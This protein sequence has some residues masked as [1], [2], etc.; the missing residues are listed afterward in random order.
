[1]ENKI[2]RLLI[3]FF[4][5]MLV[6][7]FLSRAAAAAVVAK[8][9]VASV[10]SGNL[11]Y[12]IAGTG[13]VKADAAKY[14]ELAA[15]YK[16]GTVSVREG[17][18]VKRGDLLFAYDVKQLKEIEKEKE[19][20]LK[21]LRLQYQAIGVTDVST[22]NS[23]EKDAALLAVEN[24]KEDIDA[25]KRALSDVKKT[26]KENKEKA[27]KEAADALEETKASGKTA[28]KMSKRAVQ[29]LEEELSKMLLPEEEAGDVI[30]VYKKAA[31]E[32]IDSSISSALQ[33]VFQYYYGEGYAEHCQKAEQAKKD[34]QRARE[35][36]AGIEQKWQNVN[37]E[38]YRM[39]DP[40]TSVRN[41]YY[42]QTA[43]KKAELKGANRAVEDAKEAY[44]KLTGKDEK[45]TE[46]LNNLRTALIN[47]TAD[48]DVLEAAVYR[49]LTEDKKADA[50]VLEAVRT[51]ISRAEE[52]EKAVEEEWEKKQ[53]TA[54][55]KAEVILKDLE[56]IKAG[57]YDYSKEEQA[58][59]KNLQEAERTL[60]AAE[61][62]QNST[63]EKGR[64]AREGEEKKEAS[65]NIDRSVL[66]IDI[67]KAA[68]ELKQ[69]QN[70][71]N[72]KGKIH[73]PADGAVTTNNLEPGLLL[74]G[75]E[76]LVITTGG[77]GLTMS[78]D[79]EDMKHFAAGDTVTVKTGDGE[80]TV[81][82][83]IEN[84]ELTGQDNKV[85]FTAILP[86]GNYQAGESLA[87]TLSKDSSDY[88]NCIP[89][90]A[91]RQ[92]SQGTYIL[93]VKEKE[94]VLGTI[95]EAFRMNVTVLS[96]DFKMAAVEA[97]LTEK[98]QIITTGNRS[99]KEGDRVRVYE[100][101]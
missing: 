18:E 8:V 66:M 52:D 54:R 90:Q 75:Q 84:I 9:R 45:L 6:C 65:E 2:K 44:E 64:E 55:E 63:E 50:S 38:D 21:K 20:A 39:Y 94:S 41:A 51:K 80:N 24:A 36:L 95:Q 29:D 61:L 4:A 30:N 72:G 76:K 92:D 81:T 68:Q 10:K 33:V 98:D 73:A 70:I 16:I 7:T 15:G 12:E 69:L 77:Y 82:S 99:F 86:E 32:G 71:I 37:L 62:Q 56:A 11:T 91:L 5:L 27:Y 17:Q 26:V 100:V 58:F 46:A 78:A 31:A 28:V 79:A 53:K 101:E 93:L 85:N 34:L 47:K 87:F 13:I 3:G 83:Q 1:M 22:D 88:R 67:D 35:D 48:A 42:E 96:M 40:D 19:N 74:T 25:A 57:S 49:M 14:M 43:A 60:K 89:I 59:K 97:S 23:S